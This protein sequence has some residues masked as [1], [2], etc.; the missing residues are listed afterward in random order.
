[1]KSGKYALTWPVA[2]KRSSSAALDELPDRVAVRADDHAAL[3]RRVVGQLG[4]ADHIDIPAREVLGLGRDLGDD[5]FLVVVFLGHD[6]VP[7]APRKAGFAAGANLLSYHRLET[8]RPVPAPS[9]HPMTH[10]P[11]LRIDDCHALAAL[12]RPDRRRRRSSASEPRWTRRASGRP[13]SS[14][15]ARQSG[16]SGASASTKRSPTRRPSSCPTANA[17]RR[18]AASAASTTRCS[19]TAPTDRRR[20]SHSAEG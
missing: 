17:T 3:D 18:R 14:C 19:S 16:G 7:A 9:R 13:V 12:S 15:R 8:A 10:D 11:T 1:M 4:A 2:L 5:G 6:V 20:S